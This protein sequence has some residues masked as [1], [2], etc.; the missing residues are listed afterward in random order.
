MAEARDI[1]RAATAFHEAGHA[2]GSLRQGWVPRLISIRRTDGF[3]GRMFPDHAAWR[4]LDAAGDEQ[5]LQEVAVRHAVV[6]LAGPVAEQ[7]FLHP[8]MRPFSDLPPWDERH[9]ADFLVTRDL[10]EACAADATDWRRLFL[11]AESRVVPLVF[12]GWPSIEGVAR[13]LLA[14]TLLT[15]EDI[16]D[17]VD[18]SRTGAN[19][20][21]GLEDRTR[22]SSPKSRSSV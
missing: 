8:R 18:L 4:E 15:G 21:A 12:V 13:A 11:L 17:A 14:R 2:L 6:R 5:T 3:A 16:L 22:Y 19:S 9:G 10:L 7:R 1:E 20:S